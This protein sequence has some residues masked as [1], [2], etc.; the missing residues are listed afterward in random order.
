MAVNQV[1]GEAINFRLVEG[2]V[3]QLMGQWRVEAAETPGQTRVTLTVRA[4]TGARGRWLLRMTAKFIE[5]KSDRLIAV[6]SN[7]VMALEAK[8]VKRSPK[9]QVDKSSV[10]LPEI[11]VKPAFNLFEDEAQQQTLEALA[12]T[13]LPADEFDAGVQNQ[14][15]A[16]VVEVRARYETGRLELYQ[17]GLKAVDQMAQAM[18]NRPSFVALAPAERSA[19]LAAIRENQAN[20]HFW[21]ETKPA[22]FFS[23][24]WEDVVFLYC[25]HPE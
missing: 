9:G 13:L 4:A 6:F 12:A 20:P 17:V 8:D 5:R 25:T 2:P 22:A 21:G 23:A 16:G 14:G 1:P 3:E 10:L 11:P 7:R 24:L 15:L 18:F 19:L